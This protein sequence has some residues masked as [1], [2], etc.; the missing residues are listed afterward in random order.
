[1]QRT[2]LAAMLITAVA[3]VPVL[4]ITPANVQPPPGGYAAPPAPKSATAQVAEA[5]KHADDSSGMRRG[6]VQKVDMATGT[7]LVYGQPVT[8]DPKQVRMV[9][10]NG[11]RTSIYALRQ[12]AHVRFTLDPADPAHMRAAVIY[13]N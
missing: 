4:A 2:L 8:F 6:V 10:A 5:R 11:K 7:F 1:M 13:V 9:G 3:A 12:G